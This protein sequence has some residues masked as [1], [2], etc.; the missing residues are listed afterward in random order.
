MTTTEQ[1][2][3]EGSAAHG[4]APGEAG[5]RT[6]I[7]REMREIEEQARDV[8]QGVAERMRKPWIG[9]AVAGAAVL[10]AG[11]FW[12]ASEAAVAAVAA[13]AVFRMLRRRRRDAGEERRD[14]GIGGRPAS[15][16][17]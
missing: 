7:H 12:G 4:V 8:M 3:R 14:E 5:S 10:A 13:Y 9:A 6:P 15:A 16:G 2:A 1:E 11:A 17:A